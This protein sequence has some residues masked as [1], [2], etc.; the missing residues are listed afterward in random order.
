[1]LPSNN[2]QYA[3]S[4]YVRIGEAAQEVVP[5]LQVD[6]EGSEVHRAALQGKFALIDERGAN[7][8]LINPVIKSFL[9]LLRSPHTLSELV[10]SVAEQVCCR[11]DDVREVVDSF[12][13]RMVRRQIVVEY[14]REEALKEAPLV[15]EGRMLGPYRI[16]EVLAVKAD[17][18]VYLARQLGRRKCKVVLKVFSP[19]PDMPA[20]TVAR[21]RARFEREFRLMSAVGEHEN[22]CKV[23]D[24]VP[25]EPPYAVLEYVDGASVTALAEERGHPL[26]NRLQAAA[27]V[28]RA[29]AHLHRHRVL[30]GDIHDSNFVL[31]SGG[32]VKLIDFGMALHQELDADQVVPHGGVT[33]YIPPERVA[34]EAFGISLG[35]STARSEVHQLGVVVYSVLSGRLP[36]RGFLWRDLVRS[37]QEDIPRR[38]SSTPE[39]E[40]IPAPYTDIVAKALQKDAGARYASAVE[41]S[42][43]WES[44]NVKPRCNQLEGSVWLFRTSG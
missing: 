35:P 14:G 26:V 41:M 11:P 3:L 25:D 13:R 21:R 43:A 38:L 2:K 36:F 9:D 6:A 32:C 8:Y 29:V 18:D 20:D 16:L 28:L 34:P 12:L 40:L 42:E 15:E 27:Q 31:T 19:D 10:H 17:V 24:F 4:R 37:I 30:H 7:V 44:I 23:L 1:M 39:G 5:D 33:Y 22:V